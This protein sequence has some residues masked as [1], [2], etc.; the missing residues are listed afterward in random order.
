MA[1]CTKMY[2][3]YNSKTYYWE[4]LKIYLKILL[5]LTLIYYS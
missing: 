3:E 1:S 4:I 5:I 2:K